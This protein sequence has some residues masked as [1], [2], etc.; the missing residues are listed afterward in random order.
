MTNKQHLTRE[1]WTCLRKGNFKR[2][3]ESLLK[4]AQIHAITTNQ[5]KTRI[6]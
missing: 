5:I 4:A 6:D 2:K 1:T 3:T